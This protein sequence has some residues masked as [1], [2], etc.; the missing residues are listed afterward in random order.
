MTRPGPIEHSRLWPLH[1][2]LAAIDADIAQVY[3]D[4][5]VSGLKPSWVLELLRLYEHGPMTITELASSVHRT[6]SAISQKVAAMQAAGL[7][8]TTAGADARSK[9]VAL[10]AKARGLA[11]LLAAEWQATEATLAELEAEI[12]YPL[13]LAT[14]DLQAALTRKSFHD[15]LAEKLAGDTAW[16]PAQRRP[17]IAKESDGTRHR[18]A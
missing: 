3:A 11:G 15:R 6:H 5:Q 13:S 8:R 2:L 1:Q 12:P 9:Q 10:T 16:Q 17:P 7:V 18:H 14:A 4:A